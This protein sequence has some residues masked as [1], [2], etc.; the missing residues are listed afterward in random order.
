MFFS[1]PPFSR[2]AKS[3][4]CNP[5]IAYTPSGKAGCMRRKPC[6]GDT[7][8][9]SEEVVSSRWPEKAGLFLILTLTLLFR[10]LRPAFSH[11]CAVKSMYHRHFQDVKAKTVRFL[12][13]VLF[14][15]T[16]TKVSQGYDRLIR[17]CASRVI[18]WLPHSH[19]HRHGKNTRRT[20]DDGLPIHSFQSLLAELATRCRNRCRVQS[21][22]D[23][24]TF[25]QHTEYSP[26]Q[27]RAMQL[28]DVLPV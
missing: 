23:T 9:V 26:L 4:V 14:P 15:V 17:S 27:E 7:Y 10:A 11:D 12:R 18:L 6:C 22:P 1:D 8:N 13:P 20:T 24:L 25:V 2:G 21:Q 19:R 5:V 28:L 3:S 16:P